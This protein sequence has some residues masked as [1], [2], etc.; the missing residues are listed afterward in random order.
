M[1]TLIQNDY[2]LLRG[3]ETQ[4]HRRRVS[5]GE[6]EADVLRCKPRTPRIAGGLQ[7]LGRVREQAPTPDLP[8]G[9]GG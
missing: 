2:V 3:A 9:F 4:T 1:C 7:K 5:C 8:T 6:A